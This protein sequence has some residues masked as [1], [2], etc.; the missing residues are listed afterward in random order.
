MALSKLPPI[1]LTLTDDS[2]QLAISLDGKSHLYAADQVE[3]LI[4]L[5]MAQRSRMTP[6]VGPLTGDPVPADRVL[7]ADEYLL[8]IDPEKCTLQVWTQHPGFGWG[9]VTIPA[10]DA[11]VLGQELIDLANKAQPEPPKNLQ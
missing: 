8:Q 11:A 6:S 5:L 9:L 1:N 10:L 7:V 3:T 4:Y 2:K